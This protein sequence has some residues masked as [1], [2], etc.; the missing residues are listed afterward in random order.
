MRFLDENNDVISYQCKGILKYA[1][2]LRSKIH[3]YAE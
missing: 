1:M 2:C 3:L